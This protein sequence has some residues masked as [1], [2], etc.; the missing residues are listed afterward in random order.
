MDIP[1]GNCV[2]AAVSPASPFAVINA[3]AVALPQQQFG[4]R[5]AS[6][7]DLEFPDGALFSELKVPSCDHV[8]QSA[9][10][11]CVLA[12]LCVSAVPR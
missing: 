8:A 4:L 2:A 6:L 11:Y 3:S 10:M 9:G 1:C 7:K 12:Y 5:L